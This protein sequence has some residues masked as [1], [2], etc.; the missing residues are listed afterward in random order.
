MIESRRRLILSPQPDCPWAEKMVLNPAIIADPDHPD[1]LHMLFR[2][3]GP[4]PEAAR[5]GGPLPYPIFLGYAVSRDRGETWQADFSRPAMAPAL[6]DAPESIL[7]AAGCR[8]NY[9]NGCIEDP[10]LFFFEG[11]LM[12]S[13]ACRTFPPG[14]Y[15]EHDDPGQC[16]PKWAGEKNIAT[17]VKENSTV[18][19][20]YEVDL[21]ALKTRRYS[22]AFQL[23]GPLHPPD[24]SDDRDAFLFPRRLL[25]DGS[26]RIVC[27]H[28][29]K[30]PWRYREGKGLS[31]PS[32]FLAF[33]DRLEDLV[34]EDIR[35]EVLAVPQFEWEANRLGGSWP[36]IELTPGEWLLPYHGKQDDDV[37]YTQSFMILRENGNGLEIAHRPSE[38]LLYAAAP[39]ELEG[40]FA[41]PCMFTCSG[42]LRGNGRLLMGYGAADRQ[43][44]LVDVCFSRLLAEVRKYDAAG[45]PYPG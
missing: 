26:P 35:R 12:L 1:T 40:D 19:L 5:P 21:A 7:H 18:S 14:P 6:H 8:V 25:I 15:W 37:G 38:R 32:I 27:L 2:A 28:R 33:A 10:R 16:M 24:L 45:Q 11:R 9:A 42:V 44:G 36:P 20:L 17:A 43:V 23:L 13:V 29:P 3:T 30:Y 31:A 39:W 41:I 34:R 22:E 4:C